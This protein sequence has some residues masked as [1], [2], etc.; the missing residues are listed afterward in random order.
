MK[1]KTLR[2]HAMLSLACCGTAMPMTA[3]A[4]LSTVDLREAC[5]LVDL[6][7]PPQ[8]LTVYQKAPPCAGDTLQ[9][10]VNAV[11]MYEAA[12]THDHSEH[13]VCVDDNTSVRTLAAVYLKWLDDHPKELDSFAAVST[14]K[15]FHE[16]YPCTK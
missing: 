15:A 7:Q 6:Q 14:F 4:V 8:G 12:R 10:Y 5:R 3:H 2:C 1:L 11:D 16:T 9:G 13:L